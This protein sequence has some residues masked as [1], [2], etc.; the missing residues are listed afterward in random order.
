MVFFLFG[1]WCFSVCLCCQ[2]E[3]DDTSCDPN[4]IAI[5]IVDWCWFT[6]NW[7]TITHC[8][9]IL[10]TFSRV[11]WNG[12]IGKI[13]IVGGQCLAFV[14][15]QFCACWMFKKYCHEVLKKFVTRLIFYFALL[16]CKLRV[17]MYF[18]I[19]QQQQW[20]PTKSLLFRFK[21]L[22]HSFYVFAM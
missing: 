6:L 19:K 17:Q 16:Y 1:V 3:N 5:W 9:W 11:D 10:T 4:H 13:T 22:C 2:F 18:L 14:L 7:G 21:P 8:G 12:R 15:Q 20:K